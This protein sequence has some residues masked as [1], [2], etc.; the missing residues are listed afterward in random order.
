MDIPGLVDT[1]VLLA[2]LATDLLVVFVIARLIYYPRKRDKEYL[3]TFVMFNVLV[4]FVVYFMHTL[5]LSVG[6]AFG[7]FALFG[8]LRYRTITIPI[9]EMTYLFTVVVVAIINS[10]T[11]AELGISL[12]VVSNLMIII[13]IYFLENVWERT[14]QGFKT[15]VYEKIDNVKAQNH[16]PLLDDLRERTGLDITHVDI[17]NINFLNNSATIKIYYNLR[18]SEG[19][20]RVVEKN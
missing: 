16:I 11:T 9:K 3:F 18:G 14:P 12:L 15:I 4:F 2:K 5:Q 10:L 19:V 13:T 6:F 20:R 8:I 7:M 1:E 17:D